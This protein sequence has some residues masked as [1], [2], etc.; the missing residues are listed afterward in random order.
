M[1]KQ[2]LKE[3]LKEFDKDEIIAIA[4]KQGGGFVYI[5]RAGDT[6]LIEKVMKDFVAGMKT[7]LEAN[8][9]RLRSLVT[10]PIKFKDEDES[11]REHEV[12]IYAHRIYQTYGSI[13]NQE[14]YFKH[15]KPIMERK[16]IETYHKEVDNCTAIVVPGKEHGDF[17]FKEE[18]DKKYG[19]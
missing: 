12:R 1:A 19:K 18:F 13:I 14:D 15:Y 7:R 10:T 8:K 6:K 4:A 9:K 11:K 5:G 2:N 3:F 17:W 16:V